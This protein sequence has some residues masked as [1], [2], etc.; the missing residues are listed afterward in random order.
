MTRLMINKIIRKLKPLARGFGLA[1]IL[2]IIGMVV[3]IFIG[4]QSIGQLDQLRPALKTLISSSTGMQVELSSISGEWPAL[5]PVIQLQAVDL[6]DIDGESVFRLERGRADLDILKSIQQQTT[7]WRDLTV[8][9]LE[10]SL[11]ENAQGNWRLKGFVGQSDQDLALILKPF[12]HSQLIR[13][14]S[15]IFNLTSY[16]GR[17][18]QLYGDQVLIENDFDFHRSQMSLRLEEDG[19]PAKFILEAYGDPTGGSNFSAKGYLNF[20][21]LNLTQS[22]KTFTQ[23]FVP[24]LAN[25]LGHSEVKAG[26]EIWLD[27]KPDLELNFQGDIKLSKIPLNWISEDIPPVS[28]L[29]PN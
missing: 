5:L 8:E 21:S 6:L 4:R 23:S 17:K 27:I 1:A 7:I 13:L 9:K 12:I 2:L 15:I 14:D 11:V 3:T 26:G 10:L 22:L 28:E 20:E 29:K 24:E 18:I 25:T 16:S 19:L